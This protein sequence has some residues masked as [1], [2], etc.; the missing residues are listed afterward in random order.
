VAVA[1][2]PGCGGAIEFKVGSSAVVICDY[3]RSIVARTDRGLQDLGKVA[4]LIDTGSPLRR[5]LPGRFHGTGFRLAGRTQMKHPAGG[6]WDEWYA[7]FDDGRWGWIA[8]AQGKYYVTFKTAAEDV[9]PLSAIEVGG[10]YRSLV[11][12]E[13]SKATIGS[14]EGEIP[15]RPQPGVSYEYADLSGAGDRFATIDYSEEPPLLFAGE[16]TTLTELGINVDIEPARKSRVKVEKLSCSRCGGALNLV[17]PDSAQRIVCPN[18]GALHDISEG[19][20]QYLETVKPRPG[21]LLVPLGQQGTIDG[22]EYV[23]AGFM[24]RYVT[25]DEKYFWTEYLLFNPKSKSYAWLVDSD[26]HWSYVLSLNAGDVSDQDRPGAA[27]TIQSSGR[28][29]RL[30]S[31]ATATVSYVVGEF[32][33]RVEVGETARAVDYIAPPLGISKEISGQSGSEEI[34]YSSARYMAPADVEKTFSVSGLPRPSTV[35]MMQ[36]HEGAHVGKTWASLVAA[37]LLVAIV[38]ALRPAPT[39]FSE[40]FRFDQ[41]GDWSDSTTA[42]ATD[43]ATTRSHP[44]GTATTFTKPFTL[45]GGRNVEIDGYAGVNNEWLYVSGDLFNE[46]SGMIESFELPI[47]WYEGYD[48]GEHWSEGGRERKAYLAAVPAGTYSLRL[49]GQWEPNKTPPAVLIKAREGAFRWPYFLV[50]FVLISLPPIVLLGR[51]GSFETQRWS[52]AMFTPVGTARTSS[53]DSDDE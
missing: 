22:H 28:N 16:Q 29:Y 35:G 15:W 40:S 18:C 42:A 41:Q 11:V 9:P 44:A 52:D 21:S 20:L 26:D 10:Q 1:N 33:W 3:C 36:P 12:T 6:V 53:S 39:V 23:V 47:E 27:R 25:L 5:D 4:A 48:G 38:L 7:A 45:S 2:C 13:V 51:R 24:E 32:Y 43:P 37:L 8:E 19:N 50:A 46:K 34:N 49:E 17:A 30:F 14:A 31:D